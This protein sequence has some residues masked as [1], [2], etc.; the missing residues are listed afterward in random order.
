MVDGLAQRH[1]RHSPT[2]SRGAIGGISG[3]GPPRRYGAAG[4]GS[5]ILGDMTVPS[6]SADIPQELLAD[7]RRA[8][9]GQVAAIK[10]CA[11]RLDRN[12]TDREALEFFRREVHKVRGSAGSYGFPEASDLAAEME[13]TARDW[14]AHAD[15]VQMDRGAVARWFTKRLTE[16]VNPDTTDRTPT[17]GARQLEGE[18]TVPDVICIE[19][20]H[21]LAEL[22]AYGLA[23]RG[24]RYAT[25]G[26][27]AEALAALLVLKTGGRRPVVLLDVDLPGLD[28]FSLFEQL[29]AERPGVFRV[30]F[31]SVH[32]QEEEQM[33]ALEAGAL[34]YLVK[35]L[36]L[37]VVLEKVR[38]WVGR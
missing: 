18:S 16:V 19:D 3:A 13:D 5:E 23:S 29:E 32:S 10:A 30:V 15:E 11:D 17:P 24:Y 33:R 34:D 22:L 1:V 28:G 7:Y 8:V 9:A 31:T 36:S 6:D 26:N 20:D 35:P 2:A 21:S 27:G 38:R 25:F 12:P 14:I 37:R 4:R